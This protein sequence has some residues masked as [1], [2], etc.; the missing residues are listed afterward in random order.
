M[1]N[2][3]AFPGL[4]LS[5][6]LVAAGCTDGGAETTTSTT[7]AATTTST[8]GATTTATQATTTSP[9]T[10]TEPE[11]DPLVVWADQTRAAVLEGVAADFEADTGVPVAIEQIDFD[12][13]RQQVL[14]AA[15][16][17]V[18]PDVFV[19]T[20]RWLDELAAA[21]VPAE[22]DLP[23]PE[24][25]YPVATAAFTIDGNLYGVPYAI[26]GLGLLRNTDLV[27]DA[28]SSY[29]DLVGSCEALAGAIEHCLG[30]PAGNAYVHQAFIHGFGG[31]LF[32]H[33]E[34][35]FDTGDVGLDGE[36]ALAAA[37][38]L[39]A[40]VAA[41]LFDPAVDATT[42]VDLFVRGVEPYLWNSPELIPT[43]EAA[44]IPFEATRFP[45]I[46]GGRPIPFVEVAGFMVSASSEQ[47]VVAQ[48]F[49][50]E[51]VN[52]EVVM[53]D[54]YEAGG[55]G[56][57]HRLA[58]GLAVADDPALEAFTPVDAEPVHL[59][60]NIRRFDEVWSAV[61]TAISVIYAQDYSRVESPRGA[62]RAA[63]EAVRASVS[64]G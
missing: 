9:T 60:P 34:T 44:G 62:F 46:D 32:G 53:F 51:Y 22:I 40:Q 58:F 54:L 17:G 18:G 27:P 21:G 19:A 48:A 14:D 23:Y 12:D 20:H 2:L 63:A 56:P 36:G 42:S 11:V 33:D 59:R 55:R 25:Y 26:E 10:T 52:S 47:P 15:P 45:S 7:A 3:K 6:A 61:E 29:A 57:A 1:R 37:D 28:P 39:D 5:L 13:I 49:V 16:A 35:G 41:G 38:F 64:G 24:D 43:V 30:I 50:T 4:F 8:T 31:Y